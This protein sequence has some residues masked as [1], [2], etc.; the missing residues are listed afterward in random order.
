MSGKHLIS[1]GERLA[2]A[3]YKQITITQREK[4]EDCN[5][6]F[7]AGFLYGKF[8]NLHSM[9]ALYNAATCWPIGD[10]D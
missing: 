9:V 1:E 5:F 2:T 3:L 7:L 8:G 6:E 4:L 10:I